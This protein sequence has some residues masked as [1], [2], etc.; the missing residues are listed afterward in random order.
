[1]EGGLFCQ[2]QAF[3]Y[4]RLSL[5]GHLHEVVPLLLNVRLGDEG[6]AHSEHLLFDRPP[7]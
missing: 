3:V 5:K 7:A 4:D 1:M 6:G 2:A